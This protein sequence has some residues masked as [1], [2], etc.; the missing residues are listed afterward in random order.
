[1]I[2]KDGWE[3]FVDE[4]RRT[5][6]PIVCFGAGAI[7]TFIEGLFVDYGLWDKIAFFLDNNPQKEG[8][9]I[10][11]SREIPII[12]VNTFRE[13]KLTDFIFLIVIES[14]IAIEKQFSQYS[15]WR[16]ISSYAYIR[17]N[18]E[19]QQKV[20]QPYDLLEKKGCRIPK[21]IHYCWFGKGEKTELHKR[22][23]SSWKRY[24]PDYQIVE[25]N[26]DNY[27]I[28][29]N[30]YM[31]QAYA[32]GKWAY[33]SDYARMDIIYH[34]GGIYLDTDV[35]LLKS[36]DSLLGLEAFIAHGQWPAVNSG[37]GL[38]AVKGNPVLKE[39]LEDERSFAP[40]VQEDGTLNMTQNGFYE[41]SALRRHGFKRY[42]L[43]QEI[44]GMLVLPSEIMA[45]ASVLGKDIFVTDR[46]ISIHHCE[47]SWASKKTL[48]ER[49]ETMSYQQEVHNHGV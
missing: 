6:K 40:F 42:F 32:A 7:A 8:K 10:G 34:H 15:E 41:T 46:T 13:K 45:T 17:L 16:N 35:E 37:A 49:K 29:Q 26:E 33:V 18:K 11:I 30:L 2:V 23:L 48:D 9:T 19:L 25:W 14:Y 28:K 20:K 24:C 1:M 44:N 3:N 31:K 27:D 22:C 39:I 43:M 21:V 38:G 12:A 4:V 5:G 47:G 36:L